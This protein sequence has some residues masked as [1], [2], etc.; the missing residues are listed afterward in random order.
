VKQWKYPRKRN[1]PE[2]E[3]IAEPE[4][5]NEPDAEVAAE[6][7]KRDCVR[8]AGF[9]LPSRSSTHYLW[10][11]NFYPIREYPPLWFT[12]AHPKKK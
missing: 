3:Q 2:A 9:A 4:P 6:Q 1:Q 7:R 12:A 8:N 10:G 5:S 11:G